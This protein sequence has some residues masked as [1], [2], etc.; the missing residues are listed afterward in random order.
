[1]TVTM[2][3]FCGSPG[4]SSKKDAS[5]GQTCSMTLQLHSIKVLDEQFTGTTALFFQDKTLGNIAP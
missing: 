1:M 2:L 4:G 5:F 3:N